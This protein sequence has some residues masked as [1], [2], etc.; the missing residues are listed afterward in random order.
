[1][2]RKKIKKNMCSQKTSIQRSNLIQSQ[3]TYTIGLSVRSHSLVI[4]QRPRQTR[5]RQVRPGT[6]R[7]SQLQAR[8]DIVISAVLL[9][10]LMP[11]FL[12]REGGE[13]LT[14]HSI[15]RVRLRYAAHA[16]EEQKCWGELLRN[17]KSLTS[18][19]G[20][21]WIKNAKDFLLRN[22]NAEPSYWGTENP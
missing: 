12:W 18:N 13:E 19:F 2:S 17:R 22:K 10:S 21:K 5:Y 9:A 8:T 3:S 16:A 14:R 15:L 1:M 20:E 4:S 6:V 7:Y 11:F